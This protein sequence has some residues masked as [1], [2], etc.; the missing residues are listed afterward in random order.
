MAL[1]TRPCIGVSDNPQ[2]RPAH[3][4]I[5][6]WRSRR[7]ESQSQVQVFERSD[8]LQAEFRP[9]K[10]SRNTTIRG[11]RY[12]ANPIAFSGLAVADATGLRRVEQLPAR[13]EELV[14]FNPGQSRAARIN[15]TSGRNANCPTHGAVYR[16]QERLAVITEPIPRSALA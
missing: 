10:E 6:W 11:R 9:E 1:K 4:I 16:A 2:Y 12:P 13:R 7:D 15:L 8:L 3:R 5:I 14:V